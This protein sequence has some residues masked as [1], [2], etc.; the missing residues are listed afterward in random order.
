MSDSTTEQTTDTSAAPAAL[1]TPEQLAETL[2]D[3]QLPGR[4]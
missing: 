2:N 1:I 4:R 3:R